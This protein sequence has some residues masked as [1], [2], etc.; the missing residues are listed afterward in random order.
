MNRDLQG[1]KPE[2]PTDVCKVLHLTGNQG[3]AN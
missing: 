2:K 1:R 3:T